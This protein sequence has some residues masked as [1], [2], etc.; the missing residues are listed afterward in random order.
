MKKFLLAS[1]GLATLGAASTAT[2]PAAAQECPVDRPVN[3]AGLGYESHAFHTEVVSFIM[4]E[5]YGCEV[6]SIPV[7]TLAGFTGLARGD[8]D[9]NMEVWTANPPPAWQE[10]LDAGTLVDL[11][12]NFPAALEGW[13]VPRYLVEGPDAPAPDLKT[14]QDLA[15][16]A[17]L[18]ADP[19]DPDKGRVYNCVAGWVCEVINTQKLIAY[20]LDDLYTNF[21]PGSGGAMAAEIVSRVRR[22]RPVVFYYWAPTGLFG[23]IGDDLIQL[24]EA[25]HDPEIWEEMREA[26]AP[27]RATAYPSSPVHVA[28]NAEFAAAAPELAELLTNYETTT[29]E[30]SQAVAYMQDNDADADEAA[31]NYLRTTTDWES[32]VPADVVERVKAAL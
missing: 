4:R 25:P 1:L 30:T 13:F 6:E 11:G 15:R 17:E 16:Y 7:E 8:L 20:G 12:P 3:M 18:F 23:Q 10:G 26:E 24:E 2:V 31:E 9:A 28:A 27:T 22:E 14:P 21:R 19:E 5:G 29:L 32:W